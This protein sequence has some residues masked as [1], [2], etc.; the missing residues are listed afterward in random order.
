MADFDRIASW[1]GWM[2]RW[3]A[4]GVMR[5]ARLALLD[6]LKAPLQILLVG[7]GPGQLIE[8]LAERFPN[9]S[10]TCVDSS[11]GMIDEGRRRMESHPTH[12]ARCEWICADVLN[13]LPDGEWDLVVTSFV[14]DCFTADELARLIPL[15][16]SRLRG[17]GE[18]LVVDFQIPP[19]G[20]GSLR[21]RSIVWALYRFFGVTTGLRAQKLEPPQPFLE[22]FSLVR[23]AR[24]ELD[25]GLVYAEIWRRGSGV[26]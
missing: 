18:W 3:L 4:S 6:E 16:A 21:A 13:G 23:S 20:I 9:A 24:R 19:H 1:Y 22:S 12:A 15:I 25:W 26:A 8:S 14:L 7:E 5:R 17:E 10:L 2:E 11:A